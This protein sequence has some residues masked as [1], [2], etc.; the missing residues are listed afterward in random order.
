MKTTFKELQIAAEKFHSVREEIRREIATL[1]PVELVT[2]L[3]L[4]EEKKKWIENVKGG[5]FGNP[6]FIY[7]REKLKKPPT[8]SIHSTIFGRK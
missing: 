2:P 5:Y 6:N 8:I 4:V 3:N 7:D 1:N